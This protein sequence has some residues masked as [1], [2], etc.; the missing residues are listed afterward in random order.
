MLPMPLQIIL[1]FFVLVIGVLGEESNNYSIERL[2][3][4]SGLYQECLGTVHVSTNSCRFDIVMNMTTFRAESQMFL[5]SIVYTKE[6]CENESKLLGCEA[7]ARELMQR[8]HILQSKLKELLLIF[9]PNQRH[10]RDLLDKV[11]NAAN[12]LFG[13]MGSDDAQKIYK[14]IDELNADNSAV[15]QQ[16]SEH[17]TIINSII[18]A[19][20]QNNRR[21]EF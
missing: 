2:D 9:N 15:F 17:R 18:R 11:G 1:R 10:R 13:L 6:Q 5:K 8:E 16:M 3:N 7:V 14:A 19:Y 21:T 4:S 12:V 20:K